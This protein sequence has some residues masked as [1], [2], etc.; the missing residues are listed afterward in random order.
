MRGRNNWIE[1]LAAQMELAE[2]PLP[3]QPLVEICG[4]RRLLI[5]NHRGVNL[6]GSETIRVR[7]AF[8]EVVVQGRDLTFGRMTRT[9]LMICGNID[10]VSLVRRHVK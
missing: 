5:E 6:Y 1:R 4:E 8:G 2:E 3:G 9:Q 10:A 7:V